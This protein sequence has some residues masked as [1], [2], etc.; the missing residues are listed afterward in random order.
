V[1]ATNA[2]AA[3]G[4]LYAAVEGLAATSGAPSGDLTGNTTWNGLLGVNN[5]A[6]ID[7]LSFGDGD[8]L[9]LTGDAD[10]YFIFNI[11]N[12]FAMTGTAQI[13]LGGGLTPDHVLFNMLKDGDGGDAGK[14]VTVS[15]TSIGFGTILALDRNVTFNSDSGKTS[16]WTGRVFG[17]D[18][19]KTISFGQAVVLNQPDFQA[20]GRTPE[21]P[22]AVLLLTAM[23]V[24]LGI[25]RFRSSRPA[26]SARIQ[27]SFSPT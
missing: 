5:V 2:A 25:H 17:D 22:S 15:G 12:E 21:P 26:R 14:N 7:K 4:S 18:S 11:K 16:T 20:P 6:D 19:G 13:V 1:S 10:T 24:G 27:P 9:T 8:T 3:I 23:L